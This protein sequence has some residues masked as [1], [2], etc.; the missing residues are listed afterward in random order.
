MRAVSLQRSGLASEPEVLDRVNRVLGPVDIVDDASVRPQV[1]RILRVETR[2]G[3]HSFVKWYATAPD[4][5]REC[6]AL[7]LYTPA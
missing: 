6:D 4:Y 2:S 5:Q 3:E 1:C 7:T